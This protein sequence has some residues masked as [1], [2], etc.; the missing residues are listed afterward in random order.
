MPRPTELKSAFGSPCWGLIIVLGGPL[1]IL[2][3]NHV[4]RKG[5]RGRG[6]GAVARQ[7]MGTP[8]DF[9]QAG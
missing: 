5:G 7:L 6:P 1:V 4:L 8:H 3:W 9:T 2:R